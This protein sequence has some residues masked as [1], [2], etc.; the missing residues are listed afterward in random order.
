M[1]FVVRLVVIAL[2]AL[3]ALGAGTM[4]ASESGE[5]VVLRTTNG[6]GEPHETRLWVVEDGGRA[7]LRSGN[8]GA[9]WFVDLR[10]RPDVTVVRDGTPLDVRAVPDVPARERINRLMNEKYG[11]ADSYIGFFFGRDDAIPI[12]LE[13]KAR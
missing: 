8:E 11:F 7:W 2:A 13:A 12:R 6:A 10:E 3:V 1:R 4:V 9:G 5:V